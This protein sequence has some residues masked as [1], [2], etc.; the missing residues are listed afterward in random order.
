MTIDRRTNRGS[1]LEVLAYIKAHH[2]FSVFWATENRTRAYTLDRL[3][4]R[5]TIKRLGGTFPWSYWSV[6]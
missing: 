5:G 2:G 6:S 1:E 3:I 4:K